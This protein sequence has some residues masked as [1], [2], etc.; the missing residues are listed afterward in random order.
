M[1]KNMRVQIVQSLLAITGLVVIGALDG[2][3][4]AF[5]VF[6]VIFGHNVERH[7]D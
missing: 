5:G 1:T 2:W 4:D 3:W 6:L 7:S